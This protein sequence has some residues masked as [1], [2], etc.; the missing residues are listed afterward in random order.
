MVSATPGR[1]DYLGGRLRDFYLEAHRKARSAHLLVVNHALLLA[2]VEAGG[3]VLPAY[4]NLIVDEAHHLEN[5]ATEQFTR[6]D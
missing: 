2:D 6:A 4:D 1:H 5:A 3:Q